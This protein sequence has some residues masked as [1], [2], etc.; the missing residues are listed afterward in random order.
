MRPYLAE[1]GFTLGYAVAYTDASFDQFDSAP[2]TNN[3]TVDLNAALVASGLPLSSPG[4][5]GITGATGCRALNASA[6]GAFPSGAK[7]LSDSDFDGQPNW[8]MTFALGYGFNVS[9]NY[10]VML[11]GDYAWF[12]EFDETRPLSNVDFRSQDSFGLLNLRASLAP[13]DG[14][15][16]VALYARNVTDEEYWLSQ[17]G[18][19]SF[20]GGASAQ[21][22]RTASYGATLRYNFQ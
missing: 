7:D 5:V 15:W 19:V 3:E 4:I 16:E 18:D 9:N 1:N 22:N 2:C 12:S 11:N 10:M 14:S 21:Y 17:P 8:S 6:T 13:I 20:F